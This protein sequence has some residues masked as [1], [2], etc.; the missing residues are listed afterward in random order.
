MAARVNTEWGRVWD[1]LNSLAACMA[2]QHPPTVLG[3]L[4][5]EERAIINH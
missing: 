3:L 2:R 5:S 1:N 4:S